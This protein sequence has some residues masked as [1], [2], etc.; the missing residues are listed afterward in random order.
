MCIRDRQHTTH[1]TIV[2]QTPKSDD[3]S[4]K[5]TAPDVINRITEHISKSNHSA[6]IQQTATTSKKDKIIIKFNKTDDVTKI[7]G[8][9]RSE[10]GL[11][12]HS[13][14]PLLPR[15]T[16]S[17]IPPHIK[18]KENLQEHIQKHNTFLIEPLKT[19][20]LD[21]LY[22]YKTRDFNSAVIKVTPNVRS[23][24]LTHNKITIGSRACPDRD[25]IQPQRCTQCCGFGHSKKHC[26]ATSPTCAFCAAGHETSNCPNKSDQ[27]KH[28]CA[29]CQH[30]DQPSGNQHKHTAFDQQCPLFEK[31]AKKLINNTDYGSDPLQ[32]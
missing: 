5:T 20:Q 13:R 12:A 1:S 21:I 8:E 9:L 18:I 30:S 3:T 4:P 29:N 27:G 22:S 15:M 25:R 28:C 6:T 17:H 14:K 31:E 23:A 24:I 16:I 32:L 19:G 7:A 10:L 2:V 26:R 11:E